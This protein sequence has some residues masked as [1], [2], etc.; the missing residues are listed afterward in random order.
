[1]KMII[2]IIKLKNNLIN[3]L[4]IVNIIL[5]LIIEEYVCQH[6]QIH[7]L[8]YLKVKMKLQINV[9]NIVKKIYNILTV[10]INVY[11]YVIH[12]IIILPRI[13]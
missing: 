9:F 7:I 11:Q 5:I 10:R 13:V 6:V 8:I 3:V 4:T 12:Y 1:M 2:Y